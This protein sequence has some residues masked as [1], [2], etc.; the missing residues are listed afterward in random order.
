MGYLIEYVRGFEI[1]GFT[2]A[3]ILFGLPYGIIN[4]LSK[5]E[6]GKTSYLIITLL[7]LITIIVEFKLW[8][9]IL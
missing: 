8:D 2:L 3:V 6:E 1:E 9:L 5:R 7:C 4:L